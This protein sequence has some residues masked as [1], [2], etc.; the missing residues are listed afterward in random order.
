[1]ASS[2]E[3]AAEHKWFVSIPFDDLNKLLH[4]KELLEEMKK[5]N[6]QLRREMDGLRNMFTELQIAFGELRRESKGR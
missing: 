5:E 1:M 4:E 3:A 2:K 6:A